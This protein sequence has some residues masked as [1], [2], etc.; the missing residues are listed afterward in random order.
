MHNSMFVRKQRAKHGQQ[1]N[2]DDKNRSIGERVHKCRRYITYLHRAFQT[3]QYLLQ[4]SEMFSFDNE[5]YIDN[6]QMKKARR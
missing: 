6:T 3:P 2:E 5:A 4:K 1:L